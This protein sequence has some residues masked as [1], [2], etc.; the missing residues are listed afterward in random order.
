MSSSTL[1]PVTE[2]LETTYRPDCDYIDGEVQERN[3]GE[4]EH[5]ALQGILAR[6]FG[7]HR[8]EWG[9]ITLPEQRIQVSTTNYRVADLCVV[10]VTAPRNRIVQQPPLIAIEIL[11][12]RDTMQ[13][14]RKRGNDYLKMGV[15][16]FW[17]FDPV[18]R[19]VMVV[20]KTGL[21][22]PERGELI[23]PGT[24]IKLML[25]DIFAELDELL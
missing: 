19:W 3:L 14:V 23:V 4:W 13:S 12:R 22:E 2:Y 1:I 21:T 18:D 10:D 17:I 15:K 8:K 5:A 9:V 20:S 16:H 24:P 7:N 6:I 11:S 25:S